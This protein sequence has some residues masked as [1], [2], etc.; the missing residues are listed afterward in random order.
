[1][2]ECFIYEHSEL[3]KNSLETIFSEIESKLAPKIEKIKEVLSHE[4]NSNIITSSLRYSIN[5][6]LYEILIMY[7]RSGAV[8][9][10]LSFQKQNK[11]QQLLSLLRKITNTRY[12]DALSR[13]I[14]N[15]YSLAI[16]NSEE[17][18]FLISDQL[19][20]TA[21]LDVKNRFLNGTNRQ[22]GLKGVIILI[23]ISSKHYIVFFNGTIPSD[24]IENKICVI[25]DKTLNLVNK[26]IVNNSYNKCVGLHKANVESYMSIFKPNSPV[27]TI[28]AYNN[29]I[30][31]SHTLKK[32]V[33]F[34]EYDQRAYDFY[35]VLEFTKY[36]GTLRNDKCPCGSDMKFK[37]CCLPPY[38]KSME[39]YSDVRRAGTIYNI[40]PNYVIEKSIDELK[41]F[42]EPELSK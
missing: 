9:Y 33:F 6:I 16:I 14:Y 12:I 38:Q 3:E 11:D 25:S 28:A 15:N 30:Y 20:S 32:E 8:L 23:P 7:Y 1:M 27:G 22:M 2:C 39:M 17:S 40:N 19:I 5:S 41:S 36:K 37:N 24:I 31:E 34:Y 42:N 35:T 13:T 26:C 21:S 18:K 29:G 4:E 10:E